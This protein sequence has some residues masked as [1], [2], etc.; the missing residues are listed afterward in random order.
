MFKNKQDLMICIFLTVAT[1]VAFWQVNKCAFFIFDDPNYVTQNP[2]TQKG[3]T[4][5]NIQWALTAGDVSNW[6]P[7]TWMSHMLDV[8]LFGMQP[9]WHHV[10]NLLFHVANTL[11]LF[12]VLQRMTK[13]RWESAFVAALFA[14]HPLHV[15]S[16]AWVGERKDVLSAF[17]WIL[18][19]GAYCLYVE[20]PGLQRYLLVVLFFALGLMSKPML[21]TLPFVLL[22]LDYWPFRRFQQKE[23]EQKITIA[24]TED[25]QRGRSKKKKKRQAAD[26]AKAEIPSGPR[27]Q[28]AVIFS[29]I[30]E[31]VPLFALTVLSSIVTYIVQEKGGAMQ[32]WPLGV[33]IANAFMSYIA[34]IGNMV[35]PKDL[36][37]L[38]PLPPSL[39][40]WQVV[41]AILLIIAITVLVFWKSKRVPYMTVG[42][43]WYVGTLVP[44]IGLVQVG[45][46]TRAD[47]YTY[48]PLIGLFIM[49]S[50]GIS[51]LSK[52]WRYRT[53]ALFASSA[54][55]LVC[56]GMVTWT[57]VAYWKNS[58][59]L[60]DHTLNVT[61]NNYFIYN[62]RG[63]A[64]SNLGDYQQAIRNYDKVVEINPEYASAY[65]NRANV[66]AKLGNESQFNEDMK[67]AARLGDEYAQS[68]LR[69][70][71]MAW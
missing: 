29:L 39:P 63:T 1:V 35:W 66:Y 56:L 60:F 22:L 25:A 37:F 4:M 69:S 61:E 55:V 32:P 38:Y 70:K 48:I 14:L 31:K 19:M 24:A 33:R 9:R 21:V 13:A 62:G 52:K 51:E 65:S 34:Y 42:W 49:A 36:A 28:G 3:I 8:Q 6:H 57:Q 44:V 47:R 64:Y 71:G 50:W 12:F 68:I 18:T 43:L 16:V 45:V 41:G 20:R 54:V 53:V 40:T 58:I 5:S 26:E 46:Q 2:H 7:L 23:P 17:F 30:Y 27:H 67:A 15:E 59:T 11:L 10:T